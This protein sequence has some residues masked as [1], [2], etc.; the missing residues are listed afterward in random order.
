MNNR[1]TEIL[2]FRYFVHLI[3]LLALIILLVGYF[4]FIKP[5]LLKL[6]PGASL[7]VKAYQNILAQEKTYLSKAEALNTDYQALDKAKLEK[8]GSLVGS[9]L[10][11]TSLLY[12]FQAINLQYG[13]APDTLTYSNSKGIT[14]IKTTFSSKDYFAFK[15]YL[16]AL[17]NSIRLIDVNGIQ[18]S[19]IDG[20]YALEIN[21]YYLE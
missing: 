9:S 1:A 16:K 8:L 17:E 19:V 3:V 15:S 6:A 5:G 21:A 13:V 10:D 7:D 11:E 14:T 12:L 18:M 2:L 20:E 4:V